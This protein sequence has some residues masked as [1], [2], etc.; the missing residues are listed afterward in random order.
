MLTM[1]YLITYL[2]T[3]AREKHLPKKRVKY[4]KKPHKK[5]KWMTNENMKTP[6]IKKTSYIG[7]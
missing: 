7:L 2:I 4:Q 5:S 3:T 6:L 1:I